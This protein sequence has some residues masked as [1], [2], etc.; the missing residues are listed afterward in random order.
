MLLIAL[1]MRGEVVALETVEQIALGN[2]ALMDVERA[3]TNGARARAELARAST[4]PTLSLKAQGALAPG[5]VLVRVNDIKGEEFFVSGSRPIGASEAFLPH[6]R[7]DAGLALQGNIYDFGRSTDVARAADAGASAAEADREATRARILREV[8]S[9]YLDWLVARASAEIAADSAA[10]ARERRSAIEARVQEGTRPPTDL[11]PLRSDEARTRL[12]LVQAS[13][14]LD[15]ARLAVEAASASSLSSSAEPDAALFDL[16]PPATTALQPSAALTAIERRRDAALATAR[17]HE[18]R[19]LPVITGAA[20]AGVHAQGSELF[21]A[22]RLG[23]SLSL[24]LLDGDAEGAQNWIARADAAQLAAQANDLSQ[25][26]SVEKRSGESALASAV[27]QV[28]AALELQTAAK[29]EYD[30]AT[31]RY[32]L[33]AVNIDAVIEA[34]SLLTNARLELLQARAARAAAVLRLVALQDARAVPPR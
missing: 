23:V 20:E 25:S 33:G 22:Y 30:A 12:G 28:R 7:V 26:L 24:A 34:R 13:G 1:P 21:P 14:R 5:N 29:A 16:S 19:Y 2:R 17:S 32:E 15:A 6:Y 31:G 3:R 4:R 8:R 11:L 10:N 9:A 18:H 27:E